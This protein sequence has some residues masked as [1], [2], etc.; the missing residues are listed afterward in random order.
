M[1]RGRSVA[2]E[3]MPAIEGLS[4]QYALHER[5]PGRFPLRRY[6]YELWHGPR[7]EAAGWRL[8]ERDAARAVRWHASRVGHR[9]FGLKPPPK[10]DPRRLPAF[11]PGAAVQVRDGAVA[12][13]LVPLH[14]EPS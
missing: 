4:F 11:R 10:P 6:R 7:L 1:A 3:A 8:S 9:V 14:L 5:A 13:A 12:F 2:S